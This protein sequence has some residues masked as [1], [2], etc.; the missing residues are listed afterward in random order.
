MKVS[1]FILAL[2]VVVLQSCSVQDDE[3]PVITAVIVNGITEDHPHAVAGSSVTFEIQAT[4]D[5]DLGQVKLTLSPA[6]HEHADDTDEPA[7]LQC[8]VVGDWEIL[9]IENLDGT[10]DRM[11][12]T[13]VVPD[14]LQGVWEMG[15]EVADKAG[16]L[17]GVDYPLHI[18]N[19]FM[20]FIGADQVIPAPNEDGMVILSPGET[21]II[22][23]DVVD[24]DNLA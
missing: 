19:D 20:P 12:Y 5:S 13:V 14:S 3:A 1:T 21:F 10:D 7:L 6:D 16:N 23:G 2:G 18:Q 17:S 24:S 15:I 22:D 8:P 9:K 4:D 11:I